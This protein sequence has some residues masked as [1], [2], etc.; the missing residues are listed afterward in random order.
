MSVCFFSILVLLS[1][2]SSLR[3]SWLSNVD[4]GSWKSAMTCCCWGKGRGCPLRSIGAMAPGEGSA[5]SSAGRSAGR[6][7]KN[8]QKGVNLY[9]GLVFVKLHWV[10]LELPK[11]MALGA[12]R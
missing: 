5:K 2:Q 9:L 12:G 6:Y 1:K 8:L 3:L 11:D 10:L 4:L 7:Q